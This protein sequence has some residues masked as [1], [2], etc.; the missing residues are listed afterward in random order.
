MSSIENLSHKRLLLWTIFGIAIVALI[1]FMQPSGKEIVDKS[2]SVNALTEALSQIP[3]DIPF[4]KFN[5]QYW[6]SSLDVPVYFIHTP[7]LDM[8]DI[9]LSINAGSARDGEHHGVASLT[10]KLLDNGTARKTA[11][12]VARSLEQLGSQF[13]AFSE[14]DRTVIHIRT[15]SDKE[16]LSPS[17]NLLTEIVSQPAFRLDDF[18]RSKSQQLQTV[19]S[20]SK[21]PSF[22]SWLDMTKYL[23]PNHPYASPD[24]GTESSLNSLSLK[25]VERFYQTYYAARNLSIIMTGNITREQAEQISE[26]ISLS[27]PLGTTATALPTPEV[28]TTQ[29]TRH[30]PL[31]TEQVHINLG[32]QGISRS[33]QDYPALYVANEILGGNG[34]TSILMEQLRE[35][36]GLAYNAYSMLVTERYGGSFIISTE[37]RSEK[38]SHTIEEVKRLLS[39]FVSNGP[40]EQRLRDAK[41]KI[42]GSYPLY[43]ASN[44]S[45]V[46]QFSEIA[47]YKLPLDEDERFLTAINKLTVE[48]LKKALAKIVVPERMVMITAGP[49]LENEKH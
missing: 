34:L 47:L 26:Q 29:T 10:A 39:D 18:N 28:R 27:L 23:Y 44:A 19:Q 43:S 31:E 17:V 24:L 20:L 8:L 6:Q 12:E 3:D 15:L 16:H 33:S 22:Q 42:N 36:Q 1:A 49:K 45:L 35:Q 14:H 25:D 11:D 2:P 37:T 48:D 32:F 21:D 40:T 38:A 4:R 41:K 7:E 46:Y 5:S 9:Q 13:Y 30:I